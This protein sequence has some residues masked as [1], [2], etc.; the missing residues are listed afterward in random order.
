[1]AKIEFFKSIGFGQ[2]FE[3]LDVVAIARFLQSHILCKWFSRNIRQLDLNETIFTA[4]NS[5]KK[6]P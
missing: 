1:M 3:F 2:F 6:G 4:L 5:Q